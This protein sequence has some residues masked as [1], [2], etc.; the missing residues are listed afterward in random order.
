M[1]DWLPEEDG[2]VLMARLYLPDDRVGS[3]FG[4]SKEGYGVDRID[5]RTLKISRIENADRE[6]EE[7]ISD[8]RG[9][10]RIMGRGNVRG[11]TGMATGV[12]SYFYRTRGSREWLPL[13]DYDMQTREGFNPYAVDFD[14]DVAYGFRKKDGRLALYSVSLDGAKRE[15]LIYTRPDVDVD[16]LVRIGRRKRVVGVSYATDV[17]HTV[18]FD[19]ELKT[20]IASLGKALPKQPQI[21]IVDSSLD[22]SKLLIWAGSDNDPGVYYLFDRAAKK[23][24]ILMTVRPELEGVTLATVKPV[25]YPAADGTMVPAYLTLPPGSDGRNLPAIVMPHGG[26]G[27]RDEWGFNW[28]SQYYAARG[29]AV[30]QPNFRGSAG[31]GDAWF[32]ENGFRSWKVAIGDVNDAGRWLVRQGIAD[33]ARLAI[34]GWSYGGYAA[35]QSAVADPGLFKA[36]VAIAPV[37]DLAALKEEWRYWTNFR[38][39]RDYIGS[40]PHVREGSPAQN[41][42]SIRVPVLLFHGALDRN[43]GIAQSRLMASRLKEAGVP[44]E[45]VSWDHLDHYLEDSAVRA[46]MLR[47]SDTFLRSAMKM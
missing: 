9:T 14:K 36:V 28:L 26:P 46:D 1:I 21:R 45:L 32:Q 6:A 33:P 30:L 16:G 5:T 13:G 7:Y 47:R 15:E 25:S 27:A 10:V 12:T 3:H 2:A 41:A 40:G 42:S 8:G 34:V 29:Y 18:Y 17:R 20:L 39:M 11:A 4:S 38:L 24:G 31:Y 23:L 22:E 19:P 37:T 35:L 44:S 43:V